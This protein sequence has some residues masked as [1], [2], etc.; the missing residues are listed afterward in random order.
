M[1]FHDLC[2]FPGWENGLTMVIPQLS[3]T[4]GHLVLLLLFQ[5]NRGEPVPE[6]HFPILDF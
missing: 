1:T 6:K 3:M 2:Y 5:G 4:R